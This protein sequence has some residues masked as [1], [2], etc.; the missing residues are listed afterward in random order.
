[1]TQNPRSRRINSEKQSE[2]GHGHCDKG[3]QKSGASSPIDHMPYGGIKK[4]PM[5]RE[6]L[7]YANEEMKEPR[8]LVLNLR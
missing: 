5:G 3:P 8:I 6:R 1:M 7:R 2:T 4:C